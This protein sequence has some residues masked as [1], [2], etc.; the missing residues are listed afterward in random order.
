MKIRPLQAAADVAVESS[1]KVEGAKRREPPAFRKALKR[2][3]RP[4]L[5]TVAN[6]GEASVTPYKQEVAGS[7]PAPPITEVLLRRDFSHTRPRR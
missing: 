6:G 5:R 1:W 3:L 2:L 4:V 7:S